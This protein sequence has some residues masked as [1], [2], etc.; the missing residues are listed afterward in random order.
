[1]KIY[2]HYNNSSHHLST[3]WICPQGDIT[4]LQTEGNSRC[5][6]TVTSGSSNFLRTLRNSFTLCTTDSSQLL[7]VPQARVFC[8]AF[9]WIRRLTT[10]MIGWLLAKIR[11]CITTIK[12]LS[13]AKLSRVCLIR[14]YPIEGTT[15]ICQYQSRIFNNRYQGQ[16]KE[17]VSMKCLRRIR[18]Q[19]PRVIR[20]L[21]RHLPALVMVYL[22]ISM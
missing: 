7:T 13:K 9:S 8:I 1:M 12:T 14:L 22:E 17:S 4:R 15:Q 20:I 16:G 3:L 5:A 19:G 6:R 21:L 11:L 18:K 10:H 2:K